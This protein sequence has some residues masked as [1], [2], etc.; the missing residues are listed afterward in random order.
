[1]GYRSIVGFADWGLYESKDPGGFERR[2][3]QTRMLAL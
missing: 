1:V 2:E 3:P